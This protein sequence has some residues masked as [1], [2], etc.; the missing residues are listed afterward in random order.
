MTLFTEPLMHIRGLGKRFAQRLP[1]SRGRAA[2]CAFDDVNLDIRRCST[3]AIVG[4]SGAGKTSLARCLALLDQPSRGEISWEGRIIS[5][6]P[7]KEL[8]PLRRQIQLIFQDPSASLNPHLT[9]AQ[10]IAQPLRIH[11]EGTLAERYERAIT[12][13]KQVGLSPDD[14]QKRP[15]E[16][17]SGQLQRVAIARALALE[18]KLLILDE[19][20]SS[21]DAADQE[22]IL[23][24]LVDLQATRALTYLHISHDLH[25][26]SQ[27]AAEIA[28]MHQGRII[29][30][31][32]A[33]A[34]FACPMQSYTQ[35]LV[36]EIP[37]IE[38]ILDEHPEEQL[39]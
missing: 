22:M 37:A 7:K 11:R 21:L 10:I 19:V 34:L 4:E 9:A 39:A 2:V 36:E 16:F 32:S 12:L 18:P 35:E 23:G 28:V 5:G 25:L 30:Q 1:F 33:R 17:S 3:I 29:E 24:L 6:L 20:L 27:F 8:F 14:A 31:Q 26:V 15:A 38:A 13:M